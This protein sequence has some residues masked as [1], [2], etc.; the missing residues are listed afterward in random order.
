MPGCGQEH[1]GA[2]LTR[3]LAQVP[4][5]PCRFYVFEHSWLGPSP[6]QPIPK[7]SPLVVV[8]PIRECRLWS[9]IEWARPEQQLFG[10]NRVSGVGHPSA[11]GLSETTP[12]DSTGITLDGGFGGMPGPRGRITRMG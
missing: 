1:R 5:V 4:V 11:H 9:M 10:E 12:R 3:N 2:Y 6:Y 7:P 8:A